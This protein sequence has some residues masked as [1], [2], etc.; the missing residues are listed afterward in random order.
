[1]KDWS[2]KGRFPA[3][4]WD[5]PLYSDSVKDA[6]SV[7]ISGEYKELSGDWAIIAGCLLYITKCSPKDGQ[8]SLTV[9]SPAMAFDRSLIY[10]GEGVEHY[11]DFIRDILT[12][13]F[14]NQTDSEYRT[15]YL[16]VVSNDSTEFVMDMEKESFSLTDIISDAISKDVIPEWKPSLNGVSVNISKYE[17]R[18]RLVFFNDGD[19][20]LAAETYNNASIAKVTVRELKKDSGDLISEAE[21]YWHPDGSVSDIPPSPRISGKWEIVSVE[22]G[23]DKEKAAIEA[24]KDNSSS[25]KVEFYSHRD[26][27]FHDSLTIRTDSGIQ[28][29]KVSCKKISSKDTR[30]YYKV[31]R[32][33]TTLTEKL[34]ELSDDKNKK[35]ASSSGGGGGSTPTIVK[36]STV[37]EKPFSNL[38]TSMKVTSGVLDVNTA[39]S[40]TNSNLPIT[41][42]AVYAE[43][44]NLNNILSSI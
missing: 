26:Y 19:N 4:A 23:S 39:S 25:Y 6:G 44:G 20:A 18:K 2:H 35:K 42:A 38:G 36:W 30:Y 3:S 32:A 22:Q 16:T 1:M 14:I 24:M 33:I 17:P 37:T 15:P 13:E 27:S 41:A 7:V 21:Y 29:G 31:G 43:I 12:S 8:T 40:V 9:T 10:S 34:A 5:I 11:G 28:E